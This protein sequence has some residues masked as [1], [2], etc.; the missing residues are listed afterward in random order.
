M[1]SLRYSYLLFFC[2]AL[3]CSN[4]NE[5]R[6]LLQAA[7]QENGIDLAEKSMVLIIPGSGCSTCIGMA[8]YGLKNTN[9][10]TKLQ[11]IFTKIDSYKSLKIRLGESFLQNPNIHVDQHR[12]FSRGELDSLYP[13]IAFVEAGMVKQ[14]ETLTS[15][16]NDLVNAIVGIGDEE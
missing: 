4:Q 16:K 1:N 13:V 14:I 8:E 12:D 3:S 2:L 6:E 9:Q 11:T 5:V 10:G 15:D 7:L